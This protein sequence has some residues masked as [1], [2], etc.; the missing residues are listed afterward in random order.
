[1]RRVADLQRQIETLG[2]SK[3]HAAT[4]LNAIGRSLDRARARMTALLGSPL[5]DGRYFGAVVAVGAS[6]TPPRL[7]ID[8]ERWLTGDPA[9]KAE[10]E[11]GVPPENLYDNFIENE[12]PAWR[13]LEIAPTATV[14][15]L[16]LGSGAPFRHVGTG[17]V[18]THRISLKRLARLETLGRVSNPYWITVSNGRITS[19]EEEYLA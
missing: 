1:V 17:L 3:Q 10:I 19:I 12:S 9:R 7:V 18:G 15:I 6:Q 16:A 2:A 5:A 8:L 13:T 11:Y 4:Q 14:S